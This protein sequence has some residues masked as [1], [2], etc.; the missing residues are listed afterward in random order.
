MAYKHDKLKNDNTVTTCTL[1][2]WFVSR[3]KITKNIIYLVG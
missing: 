2:I 3:K 1:E